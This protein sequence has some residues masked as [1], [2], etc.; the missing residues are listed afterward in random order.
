MAWTLLSAAWP[1]SAPTPSE[2]TAPVEDAR[3]PSSARAPTA[4]REAWILAG[5]LVRTLEQAGMVERLL[6]GG[7]RPIAVYGWGVGA[8]GA[9]VAAGADPRRLRRAW[10]DLR[11][12]RFILQAALRRVHGLALLSRRASIGST[13]RTHLENAHPE[14]RLILDVEGRLL[15]IADG[16]LASV[17]EAATR[18]DS[19]DPSL[20]ATAVS[21]AAASGYE[22]VLV[23]AR[24]ER[25]ATQS[26]ILAAIV[27]A[28]DGGVEVSF[29]P[30][31]GD[32]TDTCLLEL[33][34]PGTGKV[35]RLVEAGRRAA[36]RWLAARGETA[37]A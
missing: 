36:T 5:G 16:T 8:A 24:H 18:T 21:D 35:E 29:V 11:S 17:L 33:V 32:G 30:P 3:T 4:A 25:E 27:D 2:P 10:E 7:H 6:A 23:L 9:V 26:E 37:T 15:P 22:R 34:L 12:N 13:L 31:V 19:R 20:L 28:R 14:V 1:D